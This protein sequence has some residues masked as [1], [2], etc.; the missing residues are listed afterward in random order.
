M[1]LPIPSCSLL[2]CMCK[3]GTLRVEKLVRAM[4]FLDLILVDRVYL[5]VL[6]LCF[7]ALHH[8]LSMVV[9]LACVRFRESELH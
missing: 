7:L 1:L 5:G 9:F 3:G 4:I 2:L 8:I 6:V